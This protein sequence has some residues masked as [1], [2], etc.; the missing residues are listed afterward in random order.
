MNQV[1]TTNSLPRLLAVGE[2]C[3][4]H[5]ALVQKGIKLDISLSEHAQA[6]SHFKN[7]VSFSSLSPSSEIQKMSKNRRYS[8]AKHLSGEFFFSNLFFFVITQK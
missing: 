6:I 3:I 7:Y 5:W 8:T 1:D 2:F 4:A